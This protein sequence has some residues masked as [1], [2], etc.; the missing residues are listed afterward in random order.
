MVGL[1]SG[2]TLRIVVGVLL[3]AS[4]L[5]VGHLHLDGAAMYRYEATDV[6]YDDG[7]EVDV[8][9]DGVDDEVACLRG[10]LPSRACSLEYAVLARGG[11]LTAPVGWGGFV[12]E[13]SPQGYRYAYLDGRFYAVRATGRDGESVLSL[14]RT[15]AEEAMADVATPIGRTSPGVRRAIETGSV[16]TR[17]ELDGAD[18]LVSDGGDYYVV[19]RA[20]YRSSGFG[21]PLLEDGLTALGFVAGLW[22]VLGGQRR[23]IERAPG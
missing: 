19:Y 17:G 16:R 9:A 23:R 18:Q 5:Y 11:N 7:I 1:P 15:P 3:L 14:N 20:A 2:P 6:T 22:L 21:S 4:P 13:H 12:S 10:N 8:H